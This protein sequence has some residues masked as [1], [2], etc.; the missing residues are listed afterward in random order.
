MSADCPLR[1]L[2]DV[3]PAPD[4]QLRRRVPRTD[5]VLAEP[6]LAAAAQHLGRETVKAA[7][8]QAQELVRAGKLEPE[9][10]AVVREA[11]GALPPSA[12]SL[13]EVLNATGVVL[14]TNLGGRRC[15]RPR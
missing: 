5:A 8:R 1:T 3:P 9:V 10:A 15:R 7:V 13:R 11:L 4:N 14:H 12:T 6:A 2:G